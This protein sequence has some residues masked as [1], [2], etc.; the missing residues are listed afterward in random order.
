M[1]KKMTKVALGCALVLASTQVNAQNYLRLNLGYGTALPTQI[2]GSEVTTTSEKNIK[3]S[4]GAGLNVELGFGHMFSDNIGLDLGLAYGSGSK[5]TNKGGSGNNTYE[6]SFKSTFVRITPAV[7]LT[8]GKKGFNT[9]GRFGLSVP[10]T[11]SVVGTSDNTNA[12]ITTHRVSKTTGKVSLGLV[13]ALG[14]SYNLNDKISIF[15]EV[16]YLGLGINYKKTEVTEYKVAGADMLSNL[17]TAQKEINYVNELTSSSNNGSYN[18]N[19]SSSKPSDQLGDVANF[20]RCAINVGVKF[21][22]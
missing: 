20:S 19:V 22:F 4:Y 14:L 9:Y 21:N 7:V 15:G 12:G 10:V 13:G 5:T 6:S 3:G 16:E 11:G 2:L 17:T 18:T 8:T 1:N